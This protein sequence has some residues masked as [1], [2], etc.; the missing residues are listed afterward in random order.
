MFF[1]VLVSLLGKNGVAIHD[2]NITETGEVKIDIDFY[3]HDK[4]F[5]NEIA[6][7]KAKLR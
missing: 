2:V 1:E 7:L 6:G 5:E 3:E 4:V